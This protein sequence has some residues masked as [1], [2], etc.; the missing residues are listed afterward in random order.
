MNGGFVYGAMNYLGEEMGGRF[1]TLAECKEY[2]EL[3]G[4]KKAD[5]I[6]DR[7]IEYYEKK[8]EFSKDTEQI[9]S[10]LQEFTNITNE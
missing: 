1:L 8:I 6:I 5:L 9:K 2:W 4:F 10:K 3:K 7:N